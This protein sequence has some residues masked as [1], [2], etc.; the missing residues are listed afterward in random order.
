MRLSRRSCAICRAD[1]EGQ[2]YAG[3]PIGFVDVCGRKFPGHE[4]VRNCAHSDASGGQ[5][6]VFPHSVGLGVTLAPQRA[7][8]HIGTEN[9]D[10]ATV[11]ANLVS[12]VLAARSTATLHAA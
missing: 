5:Q 4:E 2:P 3:D 8:R 6:F 1:C 10:H 11:P 7:S 9:P 12:G